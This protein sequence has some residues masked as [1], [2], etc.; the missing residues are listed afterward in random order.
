MGRWVAEDRYWG[1]KRE[2]YID[3][4]HGFTEV[5]LIYDILH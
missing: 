3:G 1:R 2:D 4:H 5:P